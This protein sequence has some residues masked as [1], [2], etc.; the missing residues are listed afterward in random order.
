M[1]S[2]KLAEAGG[3]GAF[4]RGKGLDFIYVL[5]VPRKFRVGK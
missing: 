4:S 1:R 3:G 5:S 2:K